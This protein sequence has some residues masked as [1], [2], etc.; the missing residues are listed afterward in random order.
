MYMFSGAGGGQLGGG[1]GE[2]GDWSLRMCVQ[3]VCSCAVCMQL[4]QRRQYFELVDCDQR[5][6]CNYMVTRF[7]LN[8]L[9]ILELFYCLGQHIV[10]I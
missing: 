6:L 9:C 7:H 3:F 2:R 10:H 8:F 4:V 5:Q 1:G